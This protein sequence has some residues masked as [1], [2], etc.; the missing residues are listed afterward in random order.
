MGR[1]RSRDVTGPLT[2]I[3]LSL[4]TG[5]AIAPK[6]AQTFADTLKTPLFDSNVVMD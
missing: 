1:V 4:T 5:P 2:P 3:H 6:V